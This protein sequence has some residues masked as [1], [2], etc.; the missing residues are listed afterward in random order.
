MKYIRLKRNL[1]TIGT[2]LYHTIVD[3]FRENASICPNNQKNLQTEVK[4][5]PLKFQLFALGKFLTGRF[6]EF[7]RVYN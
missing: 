6:N 4:A 1:L 7:L 5:K 2:I 3:C